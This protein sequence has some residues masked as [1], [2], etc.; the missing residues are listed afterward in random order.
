MMNKPKVRIKGFE[1]EWVQMI[2]SDIA[3]LRRGLTYTPSDIQSKGVRV[4]RSSNIQ[5][6]LFVLNDDDVFVNPN[7]VN[8]NYTNTGDILI[9]AANGS[10]NLVGKHCII[11]SSTG[12]GFMVHGGFMLLAECSNPTFLNASMSAP[13]FRQEVALNSA[14]GNGSISNLNKSQVNNFHLYAPNDEEQAKIGLY[15]HSFDTLISTSQ[16]KL[17]KLKSLKICYLNRL[18]PIGGGKIPPI[19]LAG[20]SGEWN[21]VRLGDIADKITDRNTD[22]SIREVFTNSAAQGIVSQ[23]DY[24]DHDIAKQD[25]IS[26]YIVVS[27]DDFVYNPRI[28]VTSPVGP[29]NRN[30]TGRVGVISPLYTVFK[31]KDV[32]TVYL[33]YYFKSTMWHQYMRNNGN[34]GARHDRFAITDDDFFNMPIPIPQGVEEQLKIADFLMHLESSISL[35]SEELERLKSLKQSCLES[36]FVNP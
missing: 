9:T 16:D 15:F 21:Y 12:D 8:I 30:K 17:N 2:F 11:D 3:C 10:K 1:G 25:N 26:N 20:F 6:D 34:T 35:H 33:E 13:W 14:G 24:F 22:L 7:A 23:R 36:M 19:R 31:T 27:P 4:L 5:D 18:F 29:I 32:A 28:S